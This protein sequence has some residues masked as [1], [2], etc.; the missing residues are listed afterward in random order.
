MGQPSALQ[1][2]FTIGLLPRCQEI[3]TLA[4]RPHPSWSPHSYCSHREFD[5]NIQTSNREHRTL[6]TL[7]S[8]LMSM[9]HPRTIERSR[10]LRRPPNGL[11]I[12]PAFR[13]RLYILKRYP[14]NPQ[15][16]VHCTR[17]CRP[18]TTRT[19]ALRQS[20]HCSARGATLQQVRIPWQAHNI[21]RVPRV[22]ITALRLRPV[23]MQQDLCI[24]QNRDQARRLQYTLRAC[25]RSVHQRIMRVSIVT[26]LQ[27]RS[28]C[29]IHSPTAHRRPCLWLWRTRSP[30]H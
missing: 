27:V 21:T 5:R 8:R 24:L 12:T 9:P 14:I 28:L 25:K 29:I 18:L 1:T 15:I 3:L 26:K 17:H 6:P 10:K 7:G 13:I 11:R 23:D 20:L 16:P 19:M 30:C 4:Y 22:P 2:L